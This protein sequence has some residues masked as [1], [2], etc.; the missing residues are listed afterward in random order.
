MIAFTIRSA[1]RCIPADVSAQ[2][3][4]SLRVAK[5]SPFAAQTSFI[6][7][8]NAFRLALPR[9][10]RVDAAATLKN[11][12]LVSRRIDKRLIIIYQFRLPSA[13]LLARARRALMFGAVMT[14]A[15]FMDDF[16]QGAFENSSA[17][18]IL[19]EFFSP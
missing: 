18:V 9:V 4:G 6:I 11:P 19:L 3:L 5:N 15:H 8:N 7:L 10:Q 1:I 2:L 12:P 14:V 16:R 17:N 13:N